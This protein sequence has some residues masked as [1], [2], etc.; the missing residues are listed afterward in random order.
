MI[1]LSITEF[2]EK[3]LFK[4][5]IRSLSGSQEPFQSE[6]VEF[7]RVCLPRH[8]VLNVCGAGNKVY[9]AFVNM[10]V[11]RPAYG[12]QFAHLITVK[13]QGQQP[14]FRFVWGIEQPGLGIDVLAVQFA[15]AVRGDIHR[16]QPPYIWLDLH[17]ILILL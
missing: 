16:V 7:R 5:F 13:D 1:L 3:A 2:S 10:V 12:I 6:Y 9:K 8:V 15:G 11:N 14:V 4:L 17:K